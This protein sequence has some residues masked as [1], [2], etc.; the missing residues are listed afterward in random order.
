MK[1]Y[2]QLMEVMSMKDMNKIAGGTEAQRK[3]AQD[4]QRAREAK[5]KGF[6]SSKDVLAD[7][8]TKKPAATKPAATKPAGS[9]PRDVD[10]EKSNSFQTRTKP[11][12]DNDPLQKA[13]GLKYDS[14]SNTGIAKSSALAKTT[15]KSLPPADKGGAIEKHQPEPT[16][17]KPEIRK[18]Q[19]G[20]WSQGAKT[21]PSNLAKRKSSAVTKPDSVDKVKVTDSGSEGQRGNRPGTSS[22]TNTTTNNTTTINN[23][24]PVKPKKKPN[25]GK[26]LKKLGGKAAGLA[27]KVRDSANDTDL[28]SAAETEH[29]GLQ[30]R[31]KG[32]GN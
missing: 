31:N 26:A 21:S 10:T 1:T 25:F 29:R 15:P 7:G 24:A 12:Y 22:T 28:G 30:G 23:N 16:K 4:R 11:N 32:V 19:L 6:D 14:K 20:K 2:K 27:K 18:S 17:R 13:S 5:N 3:I 9:P 8:G